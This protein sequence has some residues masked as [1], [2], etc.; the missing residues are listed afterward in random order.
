MT[1]QIPHRIGLRGHLILLLLAVFAIQVA[2]SIL[3][4]IRHSAER[5][6]T[7][8]SQ[9]LADAKLIAARQ[10]AIVERADAILTGLMLRP[11]LRSNHS[12]TE[13]QQTVMAELRQEAAFINLG[14]VLPDGDVTCAAVPTPQKLN[15]AD[16]A[17]FPKVLQSDRMV[18]SNVLIGRTSGEPIIVFSKAMRDKENRVTGILFLS[19][20]LSWLKGELAKVK[21]QAGTRLVVVDGEGTVAIRHPDPRGWVGKSAANLPLFKT[22]QASGGD[23]TAEGVGLDG[24]SRFVAFTPLLDTISGRMTLWLTVPQ[25]TV[26]GPSRR[27]LAIDLTAALT[28]LFVALGLIAWGGSRLLVQPLLTLSRAATR[29]GT[30]DHSARSGLAH[31]GDEIGQ[32]A[33]AFDEMTEEVLAGAQRFQAVAEASLDALFILKSVRDEHAAIVDFEF[34]DIND[35]AT[36]LLD[37]P[38]ERIIGQKLCELV[39]INRTGGFFDKYAKVVTTGIP[40]EEEFRI[41]APEIQA[42]W[43][44]HQVVRVGDGIAIFSRNI[45]APK[46]QDEELKRMCV[47]NNQILNSAVEGIIGL[48]ENGSTTFVNPAGA[49]MLR[50]KAEELIGQSIHSVHSHTK[51]DGTS[52]PL[53]EC[54]IYACHRNGVVYRGE[55][56]FWRRDGTSFPAEYGGMPLRD[57][58]GKPAGAV[59]SFIDISERKTHEQA[60]ARAMRALK[61]ISAGHM[62]LV[63]ATD[64]LTLLQTACRII[65]EIGGYR[66]A[67]IGYA[68]DNPERTVTPKAWAGVVKDYLDQLHVT[69]ADTEHGQGPNSRAIRSGEAQVV[70]DVLTDPRMAIWRELAR[71]YGYAAV[72]AAPLRVEGKIIGAMSIY[73]TEKDAFDADEIRLL[74]ELIGNIAFGVASLRART[75]RDRIA[76]EHAHHAEILQQSLEQTIQAIADIVEARD[77]YTAGHER[78]VGELAVAIAK[79]MGLREEKV[80]GI[81]LAA[82]IHDLGKI[83]IPSEILAKPGRLTDIEYMLI[84]THA[85]VGYDILKDV[86]FPWPIAEIVWQH[87]EKLDGTGYPRG[88]KNGDIL[89]EA[90]IMVVADVVESMVSH[91]PY[92]PAFGIDIALEQIE[93]GRGTIYD[94]AVVDAC[95]KLFREDKFTFKS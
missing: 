64:E 68:D 35:R 38:R 1:M 33:R 6:D 3:H 90:R 60:L 71:K 11:E 59:V 7:A 79:K 52:Y 65:V 53:E 86:S 78:R 55:D 75:E 29:F 40:L 8:T 16:R 85:E 80:H 26:F 54:S 47:Q 74:E 39:P 95:L 48:D 37:M 81:R 66:M 25:E 91:R 82:S 42:N 27:E 2:L 10:Q 36:K 18:T 63:R 45:T 77:P 51:S 56:L 67:W 44:R 4:E 46:E 22:I 69:W 12:G 24:V 58:D 62:A 72:F 21:L 83:R 88:L 43:L 14:K 89:M 41:D 93:H 57:A 49:R 5:V 20:N 87:H 34:T 9:L 30:G 13:C 15:F 61:T 70:H 76:H 28:A 17:W 84:K 50:W 19:L 32:L 92:R 73:A 31:T 23:G 94:P